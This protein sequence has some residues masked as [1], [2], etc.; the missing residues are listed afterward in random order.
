MLEVDGVALFW[1]S[2]VVLVGDN[3]EGGP[4]AART[5][6]VRLYVSVVILDGTDRYRCCAWL[7]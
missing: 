6:V 2:P 3:G 4:T 1:S 5:V 7:C